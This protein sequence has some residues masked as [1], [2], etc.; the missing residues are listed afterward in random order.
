MNWLLFLT[1][2]ER[3]LIFVLSFQE[4]L[5]DGIAVIQISL[6]W[7]ISNHRFSFSLHY[8]LRCID[9]GQIFYLFCDCLLEI[10][11][12]PLFQDIL[13]FINHNKWDILMDTHNS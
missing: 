6:Y 10:L 2:H 3:V 9:Q 7:I 13:C 8:F 5:T 1:L 12:Q 4:P 11:V